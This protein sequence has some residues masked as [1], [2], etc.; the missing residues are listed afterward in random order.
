MRSADA[1]FYLYWGGALGNA[2]I[3]LHGVNS[4]FVIPWNISVSY[5]IMKLLRYGSR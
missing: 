5:L 2:V 1:I 4:L 3:V